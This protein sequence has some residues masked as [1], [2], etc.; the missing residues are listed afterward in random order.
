MTYCSDTA[1][2]YIIKTQEN[3]WTKG[4]IVPFHEK[5]N[6][7]IANNYRD[8]TRTSIGAKIYKTQPHRNRFW[9][10]SLEE[11][12]SLSEKS[13]HNISNSDSETN[14]RKEYGQKKTLSDTLIKRFLQGIGLYTQIRQAYCLIKETIRAIMMLYKNTKVKVSSPHGDT[15]SL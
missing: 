10:S 14:S 8:I 15:N 11:S 2:L 6:P 3:R 7:G 13:A 12:K 4:C 1:T 9:E 5:G